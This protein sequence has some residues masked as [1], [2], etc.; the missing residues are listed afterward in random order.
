M[1]TIRYCLLSLFLLLTLSGCQPDQ[2]TDPA[3]VEAA[4]D[5][6]DL[7]VKGAHIVTMDAAGTVMEDGAVAVDEGIILA[8]G[9]VADIE[10]RFSAVETLD[11]GNRIV[12]PG[13]VNGHSHAAMTLLRGVADD[14]A[15]MDWPPKSSS[16]TPSL[17]GSVRSS[18]AG[19]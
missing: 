9:N 13:L 14:L 15:L 17:C 10:A 5:Q 3:S 8:I 18:P 16:S 4:A 12:M 2:A 6:I 19:K 7:I 11:G 1:L